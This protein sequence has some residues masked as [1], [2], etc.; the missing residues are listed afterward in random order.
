MEYTVII[1]TA[2]EGGYWAEVPVLPGCFSQ[3]GTVEETLENIK[4][5]IEL[6]I[7]VLRED[8]QEIPADEGFIISRIPIGAS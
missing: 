1:H 2:E 4:K 7:E 8:G 3:G 6:H 5:A